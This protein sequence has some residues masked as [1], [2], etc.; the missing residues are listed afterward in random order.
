MTKGLLSIVQL[1]V[2]MSHHQQQNGD[3]DTMQMGCTCV[4]HLSRANK[5][6][7]FIFEVINDGDE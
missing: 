2:S 6:V 3:W 7:Q 5:I 4:V 1:V